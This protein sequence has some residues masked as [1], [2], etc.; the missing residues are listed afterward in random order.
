MCRKYDSV[1]LGPLYTLR[2]QW[3]FRPDIITAVVLPILIPVLWI[4]PFY[5]LSSIG[6]TYIGHVLQQ[7]RGL[8]AHARTI[9]QSK[10]FNILSL[11]FPRWSPRFFLEGV[12]LMGKFRISW[13][14]VG[15]Y[16]LHEFLIFQI[17][18]PWVLFRI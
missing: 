2:W 14:K 16:W 18:H 11:A 8:S 3:E 7:G 9:M 17:F 13:C 6:G 1:W 10:Y 12:F 5:R 15:V 4:Y